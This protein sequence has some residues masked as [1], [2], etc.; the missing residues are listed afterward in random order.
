MKFI[1]EFSGVDISAHPISV[2]CDG[3]GSALKAFG[4]QFPLLTP[5]STFEVR[6]TPVVENASV[7]VKGGLASGS[8][9]SGA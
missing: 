5:D 1:V 6:V 8:E 2:V 3:I 7:E 9:A 4:V